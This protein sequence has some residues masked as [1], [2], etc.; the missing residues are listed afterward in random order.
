MAPRNQTNRN[1]G[2][3]AADFARGDQ[4]L[5]ETKETPAGSLLAEV[6]CNRLLSRLPRISILSACRAQRHIPPRLWAGSDHSSLPQIACQSSQL[7]AEPAWL[8]FL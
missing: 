7:A 4:Y 1:T 5:A 3:S 6:S 2:G 8:T